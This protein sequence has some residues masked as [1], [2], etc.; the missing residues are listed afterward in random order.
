MD[1]KTRE[2]LAMIEGTIG[3]TVPYL[4]GHFKEDFQEVLKRIAEHRKSYI[5]LQS[6]GVTT[7]EI[8]GE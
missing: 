2:L 5:A 7:K 6:S 8:D 4:T 3:V 1:K